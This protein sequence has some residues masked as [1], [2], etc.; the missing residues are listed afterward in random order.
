M[1]SKDLYSDGPKRILALDGG[2]IRGVITLGFLKKIETILR[3]KNNN[4]KLVLSDYFDLIGGTSTGAIIAGM[5]AIGKD[6]DFMIEKYKELGPKIF[7]EKNFSVIKGFIGKYK[8]G[9]LKKSLEEVFG[10][11]AIGSSKIKTGLC[12]VTK[13]MDT[14]S[15]WPLINFPKGKYYEYNKGILLRHAIRASTAAPVYFIPETIDVGFGEKGKFVDG[16]ISMFNNPAMQLFLLATIKGFSLGWKTG[17]KNLLLVSVGTGLFKPKVN[18]RDVK[19]HVLYWGTILPG[20]F[21]YDANV[22]NQLLL[23]YFSKSPTSVQI[24]SEIGDLKEDLIASEPLL[25]YLRYNVRLEENFIN[26][27][28]IGIKYNLESLRKMDDV[29]NYETLKILGEAG[30]EKFVNEKHFPNEFNLNNK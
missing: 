14:G 10:D 26:E 5:L 8:S 22:Y 3:K 28:E 30:A 21:M 17:E 15:V 4:D 12:I 29:S 2:G 25:S 27:L 7:A 6:V 16:G 9:N 18:E 11:I 24:D 19:D 1:L 20:S 23:Q 13:R